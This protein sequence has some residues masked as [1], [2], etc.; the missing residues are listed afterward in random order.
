[1]RVGQRN[2]VVVIGKFDA[3]AQEE[4]AK[5]DLAVDIHSRD[6]IFTG[7]SIAK[8]F[9]DARAVVFWEDPKRVARLNA[10][11]RQLL[12]IAEL[13]GIRVAMVGE[14][15]RCIA[16]LS[17]MVEYA[18]KELDWKP[19]IRVFSTD[20]IPELARA[21]LSD[22]TNPPQKAFPEVMGNSC[23][24]D[25]DELLLLRR[26]FFDCR[27]IRV[28][29][30]SGGFNSRGTF[31]VHATTDGSPTRCPLPF[32]AKILK[33]DEYTKEWNYFWDHIDPFVPFNLRPNL[34]PE[35]CAEG[36]PISILVGSMV[37]GV[38]PIKEAY[39]SGTGDGAIF[40]LFETTLRGM[41]AQA[42]LGESCEALAPFIISRSKIE[43]LLPAGTAANVVKRAQSLGLR[44]APEEILAGLV[45]LAENLEVKACFTHN[46]LHCKNVLVKGGDAVII[47]FDNVASR[48]LCSDPL[49][50]EVSMVFGVDAR[51]DEKHAEWK[52]FVD[53]IYRFPF[54]PDVPIPESNPSKLWWLN[55]AV[56]ELRHVLH[57]SYC[58]ENESPLMLAANLLRIAGLQTG[59]GEAQGLARKMVA[60]SAY[61]LVIAQKI[62][63]DLKHTAREEQGKGS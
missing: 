46:D 49:T 18:K 29:K 57:G 34:I 39:R 23:Q 1:M 12:P 30:I 27:E 58:V 59:E 6:E 48:P 36:R 35:R 14:S 41:R 54:G 16:Q 43:R 13:S 20:Q 51:S 40:S 8:M 52:Q 5:F 50:L 11:F 28:R 25:S 31:C 37:E 19:T 33:S 60:R 42:S 53:R 4:L 55:R 45:R 2:R 3:P 10:P 17:G 61:A 62:L 38:V 44:L 47:D 24:L 9:R 26:A 15:E 63:L 21:S 32:F 22:R 7:E 56:R